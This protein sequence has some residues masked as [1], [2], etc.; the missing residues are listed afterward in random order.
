LKQERLPE[1]YKPS[2][3]DILCGRGRA[4]LNR[5]GNKCFSDAV[6]ANLQKY[7]D[8]PKR[9]DRSVVVASVLFSLKESGIRFIRQDKHSKLYCELSDDQAHEKTGHAIR[10]ILKKD[11][12]PTGWTR[13]KKTLQNLEH[14]LDSNLLKNNQENIS[15]PPVLAPL[16]I[17][18]ETR[19]EGADIWKV[20]E[21]LS[22]DHSVLELI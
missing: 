18:S 22:E 21:I 6:R 5:P 11:T 4:C 19:I 15:P 14:V 10:D 12:R 13:A 7:I 1:D 20:F 9:I 8:A 3:T 17:S 16:P 2:D